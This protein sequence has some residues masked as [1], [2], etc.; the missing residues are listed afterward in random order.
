MCAARSL[1]TPLSELGDADTRRW[2]ELSDGAL[3]PNPFFHPDFVL[4]AARML[5]DDRVG[6]VVGEDWT[7]VLPMRAAR[8][9]RR[10]PLP[11]TLAWLHAQCFLGTPLVSGPEAVG[12]L[13]ETLARAGTGLFSELDLAHATG[14]FADA[15]A[16]ALPANAIAFGHC[17][18]AALERRAEPTYLEGR[19]SGKHRRAQ[20][21]LGR[22]LAA[23]L[24]GELELVE[25][26]GD[27]SAVEAFLELEAAGW[28]GERGTA[29]LCEP[30]GAGFLRAVCRAFAARG[31]LQ[32]LFL[33]ADERLVAARLNLRAGDTIF[34]FKI[35]HEESLRRYSPGLQMEL[36]ML[37][38]FHADPTAQ[39]MDSCADPRSE[40]FN[41]LWPDRKALG[42]VLIPRAGPFGTGVR[43]ALRAVAR[44]IDKR[45]GRAD[46]VA[47]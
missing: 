34:C 46:D 41:R 16:G 10:L 15:L 6:L 29:L 24:G 35:A 7:S 25:R 19:L 13:V 40:M 39:R 26:A 47:G 17:E 27:E 37:E 8:R 9:W 42:G 21:R 33:Q 5:G 20:R 3:E 12:P 18:R 30:A 2:A 44:E 14:P 31:A 11:G 4:P 38:H 23:E 36:A 22:D 28:K 45:R 1:L 32:L 43:P